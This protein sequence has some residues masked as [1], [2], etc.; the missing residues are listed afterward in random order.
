MNRFVEILNRIRRHANVDWLT[1]S[2]RIAVELLRERLEF[3]DEL[4]LWGAHGVGKTFIGWVLH[5][6]RLAVY[7]PRLE[8]VEPARLSRVVIV[9]NS[10]WRRIDVREALHRCRDYGYDKVVLISTESVQEQI[11]GVQLQ[12][13]ADDIQKVAANLRSIRVVPYSDTPQSLWNMVSPLPLDD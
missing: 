3:L 5:A 4:N 11:A 8:D 9:D 2:Q 6:Q 13:S 12:L 7:A 10:N 1:P